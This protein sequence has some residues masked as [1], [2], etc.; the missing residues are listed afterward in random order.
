MYENSKLNFHVTISSILHFRRISSKISSK[1]MKITKNFRKYFLIFFLLGQSS[2]NVSVGGCRYFRISRIIPAIIYLIVSI[3]CTYPTLAPF[4]SFQ[5][6]EAITC[7]VHFLSLLLTLTTVIS[8]I[9]YER[10]ILQLIAI[11][12]RT[13]QH[14]QYSSRKSF[15][16]N[17]FNFKRAFDKKCAIMFVICVLQLITKMLTTPLRFSRTMP[18]NIFYSIMTFYKILAKVHVLFYIDLL[19]WCY[20]LNADQIQLND[21]HYTFDIDPTDH[22]IKN[23][24]KPTINVDEYI[25]NLRHCKY[26]HFKLWNISNL[27]NS[28]FGWEIIVG[29]LDSFIAGFLAAFWTFL[30]LREANYRDVPR[31]IEMKIVMEFYEWK[32]VFDRS[33]LQ[34]LHCHGTDND[35]SQ[36][37]LLLHGA[38]T[39]DIC[40]V[41]P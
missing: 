41:F 5:A 21:N 14:L 35:F 11:F 8:A 30:H 6:G 12:D 17:S 38:G 22:R 2:W 15:T 34:L 1:T 4:W 9:F 27:I 10:K 7:F 3:T 23:K 20:K 33:H 39:F 13:V 25:N 32:F 36:R 18:I 40:M 37:M 16:A 24:I 19:L 26:I 28:H 31:K 29:L